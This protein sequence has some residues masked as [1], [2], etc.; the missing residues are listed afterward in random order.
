MLSKNLVTRFRGKLMSTAAGRDSG[1]CANR[2]ACRNFSVEP[3]APNDKS[4]QLWRNVTGPIVVRR[5][6]S[7]AWMKDLTDVSGVGQRLARTR[8]GKFANGD[9]PL[10]PKEPNDLTQVTI[11]DLINRRAFRAR[12]LIRGAVAAALLQEC[13]RTIVG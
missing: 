7:R 10:G 13:E 6:T 4:L 8:G 11:A 1:I 3:R 2:R 12:K 5:R 9:D